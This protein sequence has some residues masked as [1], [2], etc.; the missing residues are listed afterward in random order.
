MTALLIVGGI[1]IAVAAVGTALMPV[2]RQAPYAYGNARLRAKRSSIHARAELEEL[3]AFSYEDIVYHLERNGFPEL[4]ELEAVGFREEEVQKALRRRY[5]ERLG[6]ISRYVPDGEA[7]FFRT[8]ASLSDYELMITVLRSKTSPFSSGLLASLVVETEVFS[9]QEVE[10][11]ADLS[12]DE[13]IARLR[14]TPYRDL[15]EAHAD[16][17]RAGELE[18]FERDAHAHYFERL[19]AAAGSR[20]LRAF[21]QRELNAF[22]VRAA[23]CFEGRALLAGGSLPERAH[24]LLSQAASVEDIVRALAGTYLEEHLAQARTSDAVAC[25]LLRAQRAEAHSAAARESLGVGTAL[26]Y[27]VDQRLELKNL[28]A[29]LKLVDA[30]FER[31]RIVEAIV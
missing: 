10:R 20:T 31:E 21:A 3:A 8:L 27:Y 4:L 29:I 23:L 30:G 6:E 19:L 22:N 1:V 9:A 2:M 11:L 7:R 13:F 16:A 18:G 26:A 24:A 28:R 17:I 25:G 12:L 14:G 5:F 15:V